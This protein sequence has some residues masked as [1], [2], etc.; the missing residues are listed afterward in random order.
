M[1]IMVRGY[2]GRRRKRRVMRARQR[3]AKKGGR[4]KGE[5]ER[6]KNDDEKATCLTLLEHYAISRAS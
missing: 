2:R 6:E 4:W 1:E 3:T 5:T